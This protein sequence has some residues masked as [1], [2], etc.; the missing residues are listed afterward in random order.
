MK[1]PIMLWLGGGFTLPC[2]SWA[3]Y[4]TTYMGEDF[5]EP[6]YDYY[7]DPLEPGWDY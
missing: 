4:S 6:D 5:P 7:L 1:R 3:F 2:T